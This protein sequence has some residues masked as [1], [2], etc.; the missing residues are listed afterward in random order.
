MLLTLFCSVL[1]D[2]KTS[3][4]DVAVGVLPNLLGF[5]VGAMAIVLAFSS[6][7]I[8]ISLAEEGEPQSFFMKLTANLVHF[9]GVQVTALLTGIVAKLT[10]L[11]MFDFIAMFLLF[12]A[13][14]VTFSAGLQLFQTA[15][16][17]NAQASLA[18]KAKKEIVR[19]GQSWIQHKGTPRRRSRI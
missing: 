5:T 11:V 3:A 14:S 13:V 18:A 12:Y 15:M 10:D 19:R 17:Y 6:A 8:F 9:I 1:K 16:I 4:A 2:P 7:E